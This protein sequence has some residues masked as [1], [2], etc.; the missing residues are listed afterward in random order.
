MNSNASIPAIPGKA[1]RIIVNKQ[2]GVSSSKSA[3][4]VF[5]RSEYGAV[6]KLATGLAEDK[7]LTRDTSFDSK[8]SRSTAFSS[9]KSTIFKERLHQTAK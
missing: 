5:H 8:M 2:R 3:G 4:R 6:S 1:I 7:T 9:E